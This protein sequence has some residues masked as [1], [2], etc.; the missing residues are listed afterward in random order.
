[1]REWLKRLQI[2]GFVAGVLVTVMLS[3]TLLVVASQG[4]VMREIF[5]GVGIV[6]NGQRWNPPADM[7]P[8]IADGRTFLPVRGIAEL[9]DVPVEWH[10]PT[11]TVYIGDYAA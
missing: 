9:L 11:Q 5:Y 7:V 6:V 3:G 4:G 2:K 10:G 1:M 8:F